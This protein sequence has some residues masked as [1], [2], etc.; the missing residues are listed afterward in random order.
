MNEINKKWREANKEKITE[1]TKKWREANKEKLKASRSV[2]ITCTCGSVIQKRAKAR[3]EKTQ[4]HRKF[5][6]E[7]PQ[8]E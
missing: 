6:E 7:N 1:D 2:E 3:H 8:P 4:K 5:L